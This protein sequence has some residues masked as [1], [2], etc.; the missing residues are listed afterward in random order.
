VKVRAEAPATGS[1]PVLAI[2]VLA[3]FVVFLDGSV[4]NVALPAIAAD[5]GGG[6]AL[7]QWV[8]DAYLVTL[9]S[10][11]L[12]AGSLSDIFGRIRILR[13]GLIGFGLASAVCAA[14]PTPAVLIL[15]RGGQGIAGALIV[16]S[17]LALI[18]SAF[19]GPGQGR[20]IG[21]WSA[22][23]STA[24]II[25]PVF[26]GV[27][28]DNLGWRWV[29]GIN[30]VPIVVT[31]LLLARTRGAVPVRT[32]QPVDGVGAVLAAVGLGGSVLA[33][34]ESGRYGWDNPLVPGSL[35]VGGLS[36][37]AFV[38]WER[39]TPDPMMPL[40]IFR[41]RNFWVGNLATA[42]V[43]GGLSLG[44]FAVPVFLQQVA[45][46]TA[47]AAGATV[48]PTTVL[49]IAFSTLFGTLAGRYGPRRFMTIGPLLAASG[50]L[51][52]T[53]VSDPVNLWTQ[54]L[55]GIVLFGLGMAATASPLTAAVLAAIEPGQ[56]G[57]ASAINN[58]VARIA[59]LISVACIAIITAGPLDYGSFPSVLRVVA[60]LYG[61]GALVSALG[62]RDPRR[63]ESRESALIAEFPA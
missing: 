53:S 17:S 46:F 50:Y 35:A 16:P 61:F 26:G 2:A 6:L 18:T 33:L 37:A 5:L 41:E 56:A 60:A 4:V 32:G 9:G 11:I 14:A 49:G 59:G 51:W 27:L 3:S 43:Y 1:G 54:V 13:A 10:L 45:G 36:L 44:I 62:I 31:L 48:A 7:Q 8:V 22:W 20:A 63:P 25:G 40:A 23:T 28:V 52:L 29:F 57:I 19:G 42:A 21:M 12:I 55:P 58:A 38:W 24:F 15:A 34:I 39:H 47:T 30:A